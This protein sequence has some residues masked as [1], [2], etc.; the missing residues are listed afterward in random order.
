V[1]SRSNRLSNNT[2]D[3]HGAGGLAGLRTIARLFDD[4]VPIP[5][6]KLRFGL[7]SLIGLL[8]GGGDLIGGAVSAY[9]IVVAARL[10]APASVIVRMGMNIVIDTVVGAVPV[11]GDAFDVTWRAN[12]KNV[13]LL[14]RYIG[15][16][17]KTRRS[18]VAVVIGVLVAV[19]TVIIAVAAGTV[20]LFT[21]L[22]H[23]V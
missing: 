21:K 12:R 17:V 9:A 19:A 1:T 23:H 10:G 6:T 4:L 14:E 8:P 13:E 3:R 18:S 22:L 2:T 20:W 5:G 16:P 7:D 11:L 15:A